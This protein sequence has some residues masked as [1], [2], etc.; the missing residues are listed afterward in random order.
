MEAGV[1]GRVVGEYEI[2]KQIGSGAF[3]VVW[4]GRHRGGGG[5][6]GGRREVAVKEMMLDRLNKKLRD[7][8]LSEVSILQSIRHP[9]IIALFDFIQ[10]GGRHPFSSLLLYSLCLLLFLILP[11]LQDPGKIFLI[12]EYCPGG[13]LS[14]YIQ[15]HGRV[16]EATAK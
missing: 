15:R 12:L 10:V 4:L 14:A 11:L 3:S 9:N 8:L 5:R 1:G 13:D 7:T 6:G 16:P 2:G